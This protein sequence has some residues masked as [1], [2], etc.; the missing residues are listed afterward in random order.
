[1]SYKIIRFDKN[2]ETEFKNKESIQNLSI[3]NLETLQVLSQ[4]LLQV[5]ESLKN[6]A[7]SKAGADESSENGKIDPGKKSESM[8][9]N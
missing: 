5:V 2:K 6:K 1:M 7:Q 9:W 4:S 3:L 8:R